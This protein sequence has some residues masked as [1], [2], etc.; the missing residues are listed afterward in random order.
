MRGAPLLSPFPASF[1][2]KLHQRWIAY[3]HFHVGP[4]SSETC[5]AP[6]VPAL[7]TPP[8]RAWSAGNKCMRGAVGKAG[9]RKCQQVDPDEE[10]AYLMQQVADLQVCALRTRRLRRREVRKT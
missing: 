8:R 3:K 5:A 6:G 4:T 7:P 10:R 2:A 9:K 1:L